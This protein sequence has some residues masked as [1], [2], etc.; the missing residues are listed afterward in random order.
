MFL[1]STTVK[2][3]NMKARLK[4]ETKLILRNALHKKT[5]TLIDK[6][7]PITIASGNK[8]KQLRKPRITNAILNQIKNK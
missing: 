6:H 4:V 3:N 1:K 8:E 5:N 7:A 2:M